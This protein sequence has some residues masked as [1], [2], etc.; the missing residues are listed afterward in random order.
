MRSTFYAFL[1]VLA[2]F[3]VGALL[4]TRGG[5]NTPAAPI[6]QL[7]SQGGDR[8]SSRGASR[9]SNVDEAASA[10]LSAH[11]AKDPLRR[12]FEL[13]EA[14][15]RL[16]AAQAET[17]VG[18]VL[19]F[20]DR[21]REQL[22]EPLIARWNELD[23][24]AVAEWIRPFVERSF[25]GGSWRLD[26]QMARAWARAAPERALA[27]AL[28]R[29]DSAASEQLLLEA[30]AVIGESDR[31]GQLDRIAT[32][33]AGALRERALGQALTKW[34]EREPAA[35][36][37]QLLRLSPGRER[38][39]VRRQILTSWGRK[40]AADAL[41]HLRKL[42]PE[43]P[44][45]LVGNS[46]VNAVVAAAV[47]DEP[48]ATLAW[49]I[50]LP[51]NIR[52]QAAIPAL[53]A[54]ANKDPLA[55]LEWGRANAVPLDA[56]SQE[57]ERM[58]AWNA[59]ITGAM[60]ADSEKVAAWLRQL[61]PGEE[62]RELMRAALINAPAA[63][64]Q[65]FFAEL[66]PEQQASV[67]SMIAWNLGRE[68]PEEA[69]RWVRTLPAGGARTKALSSVIGEYKNRFPSKVD[70]LIEQLTGR[71]RDAALLGYAQ[72]D[73]FDDSQKAMALA[74]RISDPLM[75][76][77]TFQRAAGAWFSR[78]EAAARAWLATTNE[79]PVDMKEVILRRAAEWREEVGR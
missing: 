21:E 72:S 75:R 22:L 46:L 44:V 33:P 57:S 13:F 43:L 23:A 4:A 55:A 65:E 78:D 26:E 50:S 35:A 45:E 25:A 14:L 15:R 32:L 29:P 69:V 10:V 61:P 54:W 74:E 67:V 41:E 6:P 24:N 8:D 60:Q 20:P 36:L 39:S 49:A 52:A 47:Q 31:D 53:R 40:D 3:A 58:F 63:V 71:D 2:G 64:A 76:E 62:R 48:H 42:L 34:G 9:F 12:A 30:A 66:L 77:Q 19:K 1:C 37:A 38:D 5:G 28:R 51:A 17:L 27:E 59:P 11:E 56:T 73:S 70:T 79:I 16:D 68:D 18:R 7:A